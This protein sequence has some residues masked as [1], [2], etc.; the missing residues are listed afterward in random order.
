[1]FIRTNPSFC[2]IAYIFSICTS[3]F[4]FFFLKILIV[5]NSTII[6]IIHL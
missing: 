5:R 6:C 1:M 2:I 4:F 3:N